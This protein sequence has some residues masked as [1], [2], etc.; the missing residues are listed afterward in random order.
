MTQKEKPEK[1]LQDSMYAGNR[2]AETR[3]KTRS[4]LFNSPFRGFSGSAVGFNPR[5]NAQKTDP[6]QPNAFPSTF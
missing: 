2:F 5:L 1:K 4:T 6:F 3:T